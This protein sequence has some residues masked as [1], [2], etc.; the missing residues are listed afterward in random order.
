MYAQAPDPALAHSPQSV[1]FPSTIWCLRLRS[2][3]FSPLALQGGELGSER[4]AVWLKDQLSRCLASSAEIALAR[5]V[6]QHF[7]AGGGATR[8]ALSTL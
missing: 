7:L 8:R 4:E 2:S 1:C 3:S 5:H 6:Q